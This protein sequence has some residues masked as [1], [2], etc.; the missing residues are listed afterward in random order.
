MLL[1][2]LEL[3]KVIL[4]PG[5]PSLSVMPPFKDEIDQCVVFWEKFPVLFGQ[6][7]AIFVRHANWGFQNYGKHAG[8]IL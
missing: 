5:I 6:A 1:L 3:K 2:L 4:F 7:I 8:V